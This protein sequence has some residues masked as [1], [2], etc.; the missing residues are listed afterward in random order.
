MKVVSK[1]QAISEE[2]NNL[3]EAM[4]KKISELEA[5]NV[6][7]DRRIALLKAEMKQAKEE[8]EA[9]TTKMW[10]ASIEAVVDLSAAQV[11]IGDLNDKINHKR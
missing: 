1:V 6:E 2:K 3:K 8:Y 7:K 4:G 5:S 11:K 10:Q 9:E